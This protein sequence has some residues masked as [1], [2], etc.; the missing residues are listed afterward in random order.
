MCSVIGSQ[1]AGSETAT[2]HIICFLCMVV[3]TQQKDVDPAMPTVYGYSR[4]C[5]E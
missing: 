3:L 1:Y 2:F 5:G 4:S